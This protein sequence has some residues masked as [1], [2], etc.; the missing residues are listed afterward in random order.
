MG[1]TVALQHKAEVAAGLTV[2]AK[3]AALL[4]IAESWLLVGCAF[5]GTAVDNL[6]VYDAVLSVVSFCQS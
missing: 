4:A 6:R 2:A 3:V 1:R 5:G